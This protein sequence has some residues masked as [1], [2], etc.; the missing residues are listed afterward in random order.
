[1]L[2]SSWYDYSDVYTLVSRTIAITKLAS[3]RGN[4][5]MQGVFKNC[6][7]FTDSISKIHNAQVDNANDI[8]L[9]MS[10]Y[11]LKNVYDNIIEMTS[12]KLC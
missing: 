4:N 6:A 3:G 8:N 2:N 1:M 10:I 7:P 9:V 11:D 12:F 5:N